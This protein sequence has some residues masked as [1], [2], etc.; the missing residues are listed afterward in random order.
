MSAYFE[1][2][3]CLEPH[4]I[5]AITFRAKKILN[6]KTGKEIGG[7]EDGDKIEKTKMR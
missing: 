1:R 2:V 6:R 4:G 7:I 3:V 5:A